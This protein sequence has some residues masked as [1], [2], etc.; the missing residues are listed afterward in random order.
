MVINVHPLT[1][2]MVRAY[3]L[4]DTSVTPD[5]IFYNYNLGPT[6]EELGIIEEM[7]EGHGQSDGTDQNHTVAGSQS[8]ADEIVGDLDQGIRE[9][10]LD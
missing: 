6:S 2:L 7:I 9:S 5:Q 1:D 3:S 8:V 10:P 4:L